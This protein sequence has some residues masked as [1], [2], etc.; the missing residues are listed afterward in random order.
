MGVVLI[1]K[2]ELNRV[3][4]SARLE[5]GPL[6]TAAAAETIYPAATSLHRPCQDL[7]HQGTASC[8]SNAD[9]EAGN[10]RSAALSR[11]FSVPR[12]SDK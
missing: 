4:T 11:R 5:G 1:S 12:A 9:Q 7:E 3:D 6:T 10:S 2:R 8:A